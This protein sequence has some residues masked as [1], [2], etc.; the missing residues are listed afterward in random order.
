MA[1]INE[2]IAKV[3]V[4]LLDPKAQRPT[5][6]QRLDAVVAEV[7][8]LY[9]ELTNTN[10]PWTYQTQTVS[11]TPGTADYLVAGDIGRV[12]FRSITATAPRKLR[13]GR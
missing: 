3:G 13:D 1:T 2:L 7:Q 12:L 5:I 9:N 10:V 4:R 6:E 8:N 11:V